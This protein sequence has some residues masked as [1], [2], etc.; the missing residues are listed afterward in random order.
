MTEGITLTFNPHIQSP[1]Q[2]DI[3]H[4]LTLGAFM[5][6]RESVLKD[7]EHRRP[8]HPLQFKLR[9]DP[10]FTMSHYQ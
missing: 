5:Q 10:A 8:D 1:T 7:R 3:A 9:R 2:G 6:S 4:R